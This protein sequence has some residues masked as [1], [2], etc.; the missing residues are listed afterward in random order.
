MD[1][2][3]TLAIGQ[4][5]DGHQI[6]HHEGGIEAQAEVSDDLV[7]VGLVLVPV[8]EGFRAGEGNVVDV[9]LHFL[10]RH[11]KTVVR[12]LYG[13]RLRIQHHI[14]PGLPVLRQLTLAHHFQLFQLGDGIAAVGN[15]LT[16]ENIMVAV[17]PLLD[18]GKHVLTVD[19]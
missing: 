5:V 9:F 12:D 4:G 3:R 10:R 16:I 11:A 2:L 15:Q 8:H 6:R 17:Q 19:G 18:N 1:R 14:D 13:L 7:A